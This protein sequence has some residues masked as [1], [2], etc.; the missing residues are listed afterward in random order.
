[1]HSTFPAALAQHT[2][3]VIARL[4]D[5][6]WQVR[7][8]AVHTLG[9]REPATLAQHADALVVVHVIR[10]EDSNGHVRSAAL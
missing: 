2:E 3:A 5:D 4:E 10:L 1:M 8:D 6:D 9:K 7:E